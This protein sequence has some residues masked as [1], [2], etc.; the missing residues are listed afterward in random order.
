MGGQGRRLK[1]AKRTESVDQ[2]HDECVKN[3]RKDRLLRGLKDDARFLRNWASKPLTTGAVSPSGKALAQRM[4]RPVDL[5]SD[6]PVV[7]LGPGTGAVTKA[8]LEHGVHPKRLFAVEFNPDFC[9]LLRKRFPDCNILQGDAYSIEKT[10]AGYGVSEASSFVSSLPLFT[11]PLADRI[12]LITAAISLMPKGGEFIQFS[13]ALVPPVKV[14]EM[15]LSCELNVS[16]WIMLNL[17]PA[18][19]WRYKAA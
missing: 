10:L 2:T 4:A 11:R 19:V 15:P 17:P 6:I 12:S 7:E 18:R 3:D 13:Y 14:D 9:K 16:P 5:N 1:S 8:L